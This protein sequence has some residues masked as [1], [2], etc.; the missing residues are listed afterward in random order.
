MTKRVKFQEM[1]ASL[2]CSLEAVPEHRTGLN[3]QYEIV[4]AGLGA[5]SVFYL[6]SPSFLAYQQR[7]RQSEGRDNAKSMFGIEGIPSDGQIRNL[8]DPVDPALLREPFWD[9]YD[10]LLAGGHLDD[11]RHVGGTL[12][13][14]LDGIHHFSSTK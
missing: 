1:L 4:D 9:I 6:Q 11:Y 13:C 3:T 10:R 12:L 2:R 5:F 7:M 14:S 8:L